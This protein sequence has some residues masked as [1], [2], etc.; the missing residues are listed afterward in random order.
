[1][2]TRKTV[3]RTKV[4]STKVTPRDNQ[5]LAMMVERYFERGIIKQAKTSTLLRLI[6]K[7]FLRYRCPEYEQK[8]STTYQNEISKLYSTPKD[9]N[10]FSYSYLFQKTNTPGPP[11]ANTSSAKYFLGSQLQ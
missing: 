3:R 2:L 7:S 10:R 8:T 9:D 4:L 1:M 5:F 6:V 11:T